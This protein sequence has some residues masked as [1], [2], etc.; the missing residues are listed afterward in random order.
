[1]QHQTQTLTKTP[2]EAEIDSEFK[3]LIKNNSNI[4]HIADE[5]GRYPITCLCGWIA[6]KF[7]SEK[8]SKERKQCII[9]FELYKALEA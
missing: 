4:Q 6:E 1:M 2:T 5:A 7:L 9:C 8:E 3:D